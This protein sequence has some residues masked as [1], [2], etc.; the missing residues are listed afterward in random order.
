MDIF[1][2]SEDILEFA[3]NAEQKAYN[4]YTRLAVQSVNPQT[5]AL[6]EKFAVEVNRHK[7][8][9][10]KFK[11]DKEI[12]VSDAALKTI[13]KSTFDVVNEYS[14]DLKYLDAL[15]L[16]IKRE[17]AIYQLYNFLSEATENEEI[18]AQLQNFATDAAR[19]MVAFELEYE[20][21]EKSFFQTN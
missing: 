5:Q 17:K 19:H 14:T 12:Q 9:L 20:I 3:V 11:L 13:K 7:L 16:A 15:S 1:N 18:K 8:K 21:F 4:L 2:S 10:A 6:F